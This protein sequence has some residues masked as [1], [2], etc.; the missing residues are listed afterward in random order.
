MKVKLEADDA[1]VGLL[2]PCGDSAAVGPV[3]ALDWPAELPLLGQLLGFLGE[4]RGKWIDLRRGRGF[5][6]ARD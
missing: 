1:G 4:R 6:R 3:A 5:G 2:E